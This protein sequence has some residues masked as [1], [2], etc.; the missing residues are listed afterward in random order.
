MSYLELEFKQF[1]G[2]YHK[3]IQ[4]EISSFFIFDSKNIKILLTYKYQ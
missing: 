3:I 1:S 4:K 2:L